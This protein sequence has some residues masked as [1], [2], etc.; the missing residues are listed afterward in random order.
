M[1]L[2]PMQQ[3]KKE[4]GDEGSRA[5]LVDA[6]MPLLETKDPQVRSRLMGASNKKLVRIQE[7]ATEVKNRFGSRKSLV[8]KIIALRYPGAGRTADDGFVKRVEEA[9]LKHLLELYRQLGGS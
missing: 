9:T 1:K 4:F 8:E 5:R 6:I 2:T 3:V 7:T